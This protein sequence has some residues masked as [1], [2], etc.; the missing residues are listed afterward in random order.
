MNAPSVS[1]LSRSKGLAFWPTFLTVFLLD[2]AT[3][4]WA[5]GHLVPMYTPHEVLGDV[6]RMTLAFNKDAA[7]GLSLGEYSRVGFTLIAAI[8]LVVLGVFYRRTPPHESVAAFGLALIAAGALGNLADRVLFS[9]GVVDFIDIGIGNARFYTF[10]VADAAITCGA[11]LLAILSMR[12]HRA[13]EAR[14]TP[15]HTGQ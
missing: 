5:E 9:H 1:L 10:N 15:V 12:D 14:V 6:V 3:K 7:M 13:A 2:F 4:R 11:L 8:V